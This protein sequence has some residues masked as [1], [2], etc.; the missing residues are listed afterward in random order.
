MSSFPVW[1]AFVGTPM[2]L[3]VTQSCGQAILTAEQQSCAVAWIILLSV[4]I[5]VPCGL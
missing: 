3:F 4:D 5:W 1:V 2:F